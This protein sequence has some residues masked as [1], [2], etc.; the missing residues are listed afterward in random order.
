CR[1]GWTGSCRRSTSRAPSSTPTRAR[2]TTP[3][4]IRPCRARIVSPSRSDPSR[5]PT[6]PIAGFSGGS[7]PLSVTVGSVAD[8]VASKQTTSA[9]RSS[10]ANRSGS[11]G[12]STPKRTAAKRS[13]PSRGSTRRAQPPRPGV[14]ALFDGPGHDVEGLLL[15]LV[16]IV[17][18]L[19]VYA[20]AAGPLGSALASLSAGLV[21][22]L[23][24]VVPPLLVA[25]GVLV[26][27]G[28]RRADVDLTGEPDD[29]SSGRGAVD[30]HE[31][32]V[33]RIRRGIGIGLAILTLLGFLDLASGAGLTVEADGLDAFAAAGGLVGAAVA[34][35]FEAVVGSGG[36]VAVLVVLAVLAASLM[37]G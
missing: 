11:R 35:V 5:R 18:A 15:I 2:T 1:G 6:P 3:R 26:V 25:G 29:P 4:T 33:A 30:P 7:A 13:A 21:G 36:A 22:R 27:I 14:G 12:R 34:G 16:G 23:D 32:H 37:T 24:L 31:R 17:T 10:G 20:G 19:G 28:P 9:R 8:T